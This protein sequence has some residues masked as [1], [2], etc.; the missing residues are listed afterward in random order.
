MSFKE[1]YWLLVAADA[2]SPADEE[3]FVEF[4]VECCEEPISD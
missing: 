1:G 3:K 4:A 2:A